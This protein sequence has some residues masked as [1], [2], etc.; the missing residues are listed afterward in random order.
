MPEAAPAQFKLIDSTRERKR[1]PLEIVLFAWSAKFKFR[2]TF[3]IKA[4]SRLI[5][6]LENGDQSE[7]SINEP[8]LQLSYFSNLYKFRSSKGELNNCFGVNLIPLWSLFKKSEMSK[9]EVVGANIIFK[10]P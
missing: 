9:K 2:L 7:W 5:R 4:R 8:L 3:I 6:L 1:C 10:M